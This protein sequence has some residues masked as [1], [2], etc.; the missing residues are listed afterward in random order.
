MNN[1]NN[2]ILALILNIHEWVLHIKIKKPSVMSLDSQLHDA[3]SVRSKAIGFLTVGWKG[4]FY[5][6]K[7]VKW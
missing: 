1:Q 3:Q 2:L 6:V 5:N 4:Y 7:S